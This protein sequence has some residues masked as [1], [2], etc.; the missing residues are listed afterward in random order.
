MPCD[1]MRST[2]LQ[3]ATLGVLSMLDTYGKRD[4][5]DRPSEA[6]RHRDLDLTCLDSTRSSPV[7]SAWHQQAT[8]DAD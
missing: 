3:A 2:Q 4:V 5:P 1:Q 7:T 8:P 6:R